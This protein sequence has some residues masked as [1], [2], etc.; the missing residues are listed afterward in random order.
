MRP[1]RAEIPDDPDD[2]SR[3]HP[4]A[5]DE[6]KPGEVPMFAIRAYG[7]S[8]FV[9]YGS[10]VHQEVLLW[11][12]IY[13]L[14][15]RVAVV[16]F[17]PATGAWWSVMLVE[18]ALFATLSRTTSDD[19]RLYGF[20]ELS[21]V[22]AAAAAFLAL[23]TSSLLPALV[24]VA[25]TAASSRATENELA[26]AVQQLFILPDFYVVALALVF[27]ANDCRPEQ[28]ADD[29]RVY[30]YERS[31]AEP[32]LR[33]GG[34]WAGTVGFLLP[35]A[36]PHGGT[37]S[38]L[39]IWGIAIALLARLQAF[40]VFETLDFRAACS[41][42]VPSVFAWFNPECPG[43]RYLALSFLGRA[44]LRLAVVPVVIAIGA[45]VLPASGQVFAGFIAA[46][47]AGSIALQTSRLHTYWQML[48]VWLGYNPRQRRSPG[49][50]Q[51]S[52][53]TRPIEVRHGLYFAA[54]TAGVIAFADPLIGLSGSLFTMA[55]PKAPATPLIALALAGLGPW[56]GIRVLLA[57]THWAVFSDWYPQLAA[58]I[59]GVRR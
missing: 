31:Q 23:V 11:A 3:F 18:L 19:T 15:C 12:V 25:L 35:W 48:Y 20:R 34:T 50:F 52:P 47:L 27:A 43:R 4:R 24:R 58:R 30:R 59:E 49:A 45:A 6:A 21:A 2:W 33:S 5:T 28:S 1:F 57:F 32:P 7:G 40:A 37:W 26:Q 16:L 44:L 53:S 51:L 36:L 41:R 22:L 17:L 38:A 55:G 46:V 29:P 9:R 56:L 8:D 10:V 39:F 13:G 42:D 54:V 14:T